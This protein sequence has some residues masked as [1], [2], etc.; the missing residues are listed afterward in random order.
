MVT[1]T[2]WEFGLAL[3]LALGQIAQHLKDLAQ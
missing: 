3:L 1:S 2:L